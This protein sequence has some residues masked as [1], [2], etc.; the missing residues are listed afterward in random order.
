[1]RSQRLTLAFL[2]HAAGILVG[3]GCNQFWPNPQTAKS[4][5]GYISLLTDIFLAAD[6]MIIA[7][8]VFT[9]LVVGCRPYGRHQGGWAGSAARR[10]CGSSA[11]RWCSLIDRLIM[12]NLLRPGDN[13]NLPL[14]DAT[15]ATNLNAASLSFKDFVAHS[16]PKSAVEAMANNEISSDRRVFAVLRRRRGIARRARQDGHRCD[17]GNLADHLED[18]R[19]HHGVGA[20][21][22]LC[23]EWRRR[24][25][26]RGSVFST[27]TASISWSFT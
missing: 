3:Y 20:D 4:I 23:G 1:M 13:L 22:R 16:V 25:R 21:R 8:L 14:P 5:A 12:V 17:R 7:P 10:C 2:S 19:L 18:H 27:P 15:A 11:L 9:T 24:S 6:K 26:P